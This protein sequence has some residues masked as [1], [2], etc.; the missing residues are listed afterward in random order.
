LNKLLATVEL[1]FQSMITQCKK[2]WMT[3]IGNIMF[4]ERGLCI[5]FTKFVNA[6]FVGST[7]KISSHLKKQV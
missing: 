6:L 3:F 4:F 7:V 1:F 2:T 5:Y